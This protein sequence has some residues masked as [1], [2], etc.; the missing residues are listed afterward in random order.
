MKTI[1]ITGASGFLADKIFDS[2]MT[3]N[4]YKLVLGARD[5]E[6][7]SSIDK[8]K[9]AEIRYFN[10]MD[11]SS[12]INAL[13][14]ID[15]V[16]HLAAMDYADCEKNPEL[17]WKV[18][19]TMLEAFFLKCSLSGVKQFVYFSTFHV[20]GPNLEGVITEETATNPINTYSKSHLDAEKIVLKSKSLEGIV[21][22]L[23]NAIG[24]PLHRDSSA[25]KL[26]VN[27]LC[28]QAIAKRKITLQSSGKK[29]RDFIPASSIG[30]AIDVLLEK[31][32][33]QKDNA[34]YNL[35]SG[36]ST[37]ILEIA[38]IIQK[39]CKSLLNFFPSLE[40]N[41]QI[42]ENN[43]SY[44]YSNQKISSLGFKLSVTLEKEIITI[45]KNLYE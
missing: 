28:S 30:Q 42:P 36:K 24:I 21:I 37:S 29:V 12:Y 7:I 16:I 17:A 43:L 27:D 22:R 23:S 3:L 5:V 4:K 13:S 14:G 32:K 44:V 15:A 2:L 35:G 19:V 8:F 11:D 33:F 18:N 6:K 10:L 1:L 38:N 31:N 9:S 41:N 20:Y 39:E 26:V 40:A 25:W 45:L 34:I